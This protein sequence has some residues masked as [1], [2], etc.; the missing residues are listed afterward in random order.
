MRSTSRP[1]LTVALDQG[2]L[3]SR[4]VDATLNQLATTARAA[5]DRG[6]GLLVCPEMSTTGYNI[7]DDIPRLAEPAN[8]RIAREIR[9]ITAESGIAVLYGYPERDGDR[10][11][12]TAALVSAD[13]E[14]LAAYRKTHL[15]GDLDRKWFAPGHLPVV[16]AAV[17]GVRVGVLVCYDVEFPEMVRAHAIA[18]TELLLVPTALMR[19]YDFVADTLVRTRAYENQLHVAYVNRCGREADLEYCGKSVLVAPDGTELVR[20]SD[21]EELLFGTVDPAAVL[22]ERLDNTQLADRRPELYPGLAQALRA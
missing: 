22:A 5:A 17:D 16:Q 14:P 15:Y 18:G 10:V 6:A 3:V 7:A 1:P 8:G 11:H 9:G 13:G 20:A 12:N 2:P 21:G 19:P 4:D